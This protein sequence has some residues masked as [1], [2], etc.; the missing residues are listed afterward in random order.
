MKVG[1]I[2]T[3]TKDGE[4]EVLDVTGANVYVRFLNTGNTRWAIKCNL[5][6]YKVAD[7]EHRLSLAK[8]TEEDKRQAETQRKETSAL[9][10]AKKLRECEEKRETKDALRAAKVAEL[11]LERAQKEASRREAR[12]AS[13]AAKLAEKQ[14]ISA[15]KKSD[16]NE[17]ARAKLSEVGLYGK[18]L[19]NDFLEDD[20]YSKGLRVDGTQYYTRTYSTWSC[21]VQRSVAGGSFQTRFAHYEGTSICTEWLEDFQT[22]AKWYVLQPGYAQGWDVDKDMLSDSKHYSPSTC[23]LLPRS[24]N[25]LF[26]QRSAGLGLIDATKLDGIPRWGYK[27]GARFTDYNEAV[28][29]VL[30]TKESR[31]RDL[32][33]EYVPMGLSPEVF[34]RLREHIATCHKD[35]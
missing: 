4:V 5:E 6:I 11:M 7:T 33:S 12:T 26:S 30:R 27:D 24:V 20:L 13:E 15:K 35:H 34:S 1:D 19:V 8:R 14:Q 18:V 2:Y 3:T 28:S 22:F 25:L 29:Y 23:T 31:I 16:K 17:I 32:E 21:I 10:A 9:R